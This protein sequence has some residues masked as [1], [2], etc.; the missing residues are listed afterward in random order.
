VPSV[1]RLITFLA[2]AI[3]LLCLARVA[4][5]APT[6]RLVYSRAADAESC[7]DE[8]ALRRA[9]AAR[10]GYDPFFAWAHRTVVANV[11][12][13]ERSFVASVDLIDEG[14]IAH[15]ARELHVDGECGELL[16]AVALAIAIAIDPQSL[17]A[18]ATSPPSAPEEPPQA[19]PVLPASTTPPAAT[20][21]WAEHAAEPSP[22]PP[23]PSARTVFFEPSVGMVASNGVAPAIALGIALGAAVRWRNVSLAL[24]GRADAPAAAAAQSG[25]HV[26]S[27]LALASI[28]P[29]VH[30]GPLF[31]CGVLQGGSMQASSSGVPDARSRAVVWWAAGGRTGALIRIAGDVLLRP[32]LDVLANLSRATLQLNGEDA[33]RADLLAISLGADAVL[34]FR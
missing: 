8:G 13:R 7:P 26:T 11:V 18:P 15:G 30:L 3:G 21:A 28:V 22:P 6:A 9:V 4:A 24:E 1:R 2:H 14:G 12:R 16:D 32:H 27:W 33:W 29:C 5:A 34:H 20:A 17:V 23:A 25:G 31:G 19:A 10:V